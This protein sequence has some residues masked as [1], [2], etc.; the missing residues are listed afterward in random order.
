MKKFR[1]LKLVLV[2]LSINI[3]A[4]ERHEYKGIDSAMSD[5]YEKAEHTKSFMS[6][7]NGVQ[8][9][10]GVSGR[11]GPREVN[12]EN[13]RFRKILD[14]KDLSDEEKDFFCVRGLLY[15]TDSLL[16]TQDL[17]EKVLLKV[18]SSRACSKAIYTIWSE[19]LL[20]LIDS[21]DPI[22][23]LQDE[24]SGG[25]SGWAA[26]MRGASVGI[27]HDLCEIFHKVTEE[28]TRVKNFFL[29]GKAHE[30]AQYIIR[31]G[32]EHAL[33]K[34]RYASILGMSCTVNDDVETHWQGLCNRW[35]VP[36]GEANITPHQ[37]LSWSEIA[38]GL[39]QLVPY[40]EFKHELYESIA[41][42]RRRIVCRIEDG[43]LARCDDEDIVKRICHV[44]CERPDFKARWCRSF[45]S[46]MLSERMQKVYDNCY[47]TPTSQID[48]SETQQGVKC[49]PWLLGEHLQEV[50]STIEEAG[51]EVAVKE[52]NH[53]VGLL[54]VVFPDLRCIEG[55]RCQDMADPEY[56]RCVSMLKFMF[57]CVSSVEGDLLEC[58]FLASV[59]ATASKHRILSNLCSALYDSLNQIWEQK[60][61]ILFA[62]LDLRGSAAIAALSKIKQQLWLKIGPVGLAVSAFP[63]LKDLLKK[64]QDFD[65]SLNPGEVAE[66]W[67]FLE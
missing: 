31:Q 42:F 8:E 59:C 11:G 33:A 67:E 53:C 47:M 22:A 51:S 39:E 56:D 62:V 23:V 3:M 2:L 1:V 66:I 52:Y 15:S 61:S 25:V 10:L 35:S 34:R 40:T 36:F 41:F 30:F 32:R 58:V 19:S 6:A 55:V 45:R 48:E 27:F 60:Q 12:P 9:L 54:Q 38:E 26:R 63:K 13:V 46:D 16:R 64:Y 44:F 24:L 29:A 18:K 57:P 50:F 5:I 21:L 28:S 17:A 49:Y 14:C 43:S 20:L 4:L 7:W 37:R 65:M